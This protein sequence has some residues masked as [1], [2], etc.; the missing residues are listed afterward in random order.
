MTTST[1]TDA[2]A[3]WRGTVVEF[4]IDKKLTIGVCLEAKGERFLVLT[5]GDREISLPE[6][7]FL[8]VMPHALHAQQGRNELIQSLREIAQRRE[9]LRGRIDLGEV[10]DLVWA[11]PEAYDCTFLAGL[12]FGEEVTPDHTAA[13]YRACWDDTIHFSRKGHSFIPNPPET[14]E[15]LVHQKIRKEQRERDLTAAATFLKAVWEGHSP[16]REELTTH[17]P[18]I[19]LLKEYALHDTEAPRY[20]LARDLLNRAEVT[21]ADAPF[22]L[23]VRLG[24]WDEDENL[25]LLRLGVP[26]LFRPDV[27]DEA[28]LAARQ[29]LER[30]TAGMHLRQDLTSIHTL[31]IDSELT[32]DIDDALSCEFADGLIMLGIHIADPASVIRPDTLLDREARDRATSIYFPEGKIP[33]LP[34]VLSEAALSLV[35]GEVRPAISMLVTLTREGEIVDYQIVPSLIR[36]DERLTYDEADARISHDPR[37]T[38]GFQIAQHLRQARFDNGAIALPIPQVDVLVDP[39]KQITVHLIDREAPSQILVS[40]LMILTNSLVGQFC[41]QRQIPIV[42]RGQAAPRETFPNSFTY[43]PVLHYRQQRTMNPARIGLEP[44]RHSSL[45]VDMYTTFTSPLRRYVDLL[46]HRQLHA[47]LERGEPLYKGEQL[48][49]ILAEVEAGLSRASIVEHDR[50]RYWLWRYLGRRQG[51]VFMGIVLDRFARNYLVMLPEVMLEVD[52]PAGGKELAP[53]DQVKVRI[54][55]VQPRTG[56]LKVTLVG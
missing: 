40:E 42:Y 4:F 36:V 13:M 11:E 26:T 3:Q 46:S 14:V 41:A 6:S 23:L 33:M 21:A 19:D 53:G 44:M 20:R 12:V 54:E 28:E 56:T 32:H 49:T 15:Q 30:K 38:Q 8:H 47:Y 2:K 50:R 24:L 51:E 5:E 16:T 31:S 7:R 45:G 17:D 9:E 37:L 43:D 1:K 34:P 18:W 29:V 10:W 48:K 52:M 27:L 22:R 25:L 39:H 35:A 55:T